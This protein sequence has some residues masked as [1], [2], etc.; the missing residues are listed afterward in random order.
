MIAAAPKNAS[1]LTAQERSS[2]PSHDTRR[3]LY[4]GGFFGLL[5]GIEP[6]LGHLH[7]QFPLVN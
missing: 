2:H 3:R 4:F 1:S 7:E 5:C 6:R